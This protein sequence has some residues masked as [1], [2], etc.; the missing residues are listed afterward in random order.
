MERPPSRLPA[1]TRLIFINRFFH[2]DHSAT[3]Q[4]LADL[5]FELVR[6]GAC[7]EVVTSR[8]L[9]DDA[10]MRLPACETCR[11]VA[12]RRVWTSR[13]GRHNLAGRV[14]DYL[15]FYLSAAWRVWRTVRAGDIVVTKTD[16]PM[17]AAI[18]GPLAGLRG[19]RRVNWLQD[20]FPEVAEA[21]QLGGAPARLLYRL[22]RRLRN[23]SLKA[24]D[25]NV[26][27]GQ[28]MAER[29]AGLGVAT[30]NLRV[31]A[32]WADGELVRPVAPAANRLRADWGLSGPFVVGYSGNLGRAHEIDT[33]V[34]A[35]EAIEREP[36]QEGARPIR[37]LF[38][39]GGAL[40]ARLAAEVA[41]RRLKSVLFKPYQPA[42][43][44]AESLSAADVHLISLRPELE[45]LIVP[46]KLY[47]IMAV[48]RPALF[49]G[50]ADG[51]TAR[52]L[53]RFDIGRTFAPGDHAALAAS[54][55]ALAGDET[56]CQLMGVRARRAFE[57]EFDKPIAMARWEAMLSELAAS[58]DREKTGR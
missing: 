45:G 55:R 13:F 25:R 9:Y 30:R 46:S 39:G 3:S 51:E 8:Q 5:A 12:V 18:T 40:S 52:I 50:D 21:V 17:L 53:S 56:G 35:I 14:I 38:I 11:G 4:L 28:R 20:I 57:D 41:R 27:L 32:N 48:G 16:P 24:A 34:Q 22:L 33:L 23:A 44:L 37:W 10:K 7:V 19:A 15:T 31:I 26:V 1:E 2:P 36:A 58:G 54:V 29:L 43:R 49:I 6:A 42:E 47:G